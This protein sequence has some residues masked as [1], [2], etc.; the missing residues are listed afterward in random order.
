MTY[1]CHLPHPAGELEPP[2]ELLPAP[3]APCRYAGASISGL[4]SVRLLHPAGVL[5]AGWTLQD[6]E[7][8]LQ[9]L[10]ADGQWHPATTDALQQLM[11]QALQE[12]VVHEDSWPF[13]EPVPLDDVPDYLDFIKARA[14]VTFACNCFSSRTVSC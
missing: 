6:D 8:Q 14:R 9:L 13:R 11:E 12:L 4:T 7:A 1:Y 10:L 2:T 5:E 3:A